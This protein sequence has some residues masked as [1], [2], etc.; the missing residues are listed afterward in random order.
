MKRGRDDSICEPNENPP[1]PT[2]SEIHAS[3]CKAMRSFRGLDRS[4]Y[5]E[6]VSC[7][8]FKS[9]LST[10]EICAILDATAAINCRLLISGRSGMLH[11]S[12]VCT[13]S[14]NGP[15]T[16]RP[17]PWFSWPSIGLFGPKADTQ[18][19][20]GLSSDIRKLS[21]WT[22][23]E[24]AIARIS[25][26]RGVHGE[27]IFESAA[28]HLIDPKRVSPPIKEGP[29]NTEQRVCVACR[30]LGGIAFDMKQLSNAIGVRCCE[31]GILRATDQAYGIGAEQVPRS[32]VGENG[33][34]VG[35][36]GLM[37]EF[38]AGQPCS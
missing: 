24:Q 29:E 4:T 1:P 13:D 16:K 5:G 36:K 20:K 22:H 3:L 2:P 38:A 10:K 12:A 34:R 30:L 7:H 14:A 21:A 27:T 23:A 19:V 9:S 28:V 25:G 26:L 8:S 37:L 6:G 32:D 15:G 17:R 18:I 31:D 33:A 35:V 11:I